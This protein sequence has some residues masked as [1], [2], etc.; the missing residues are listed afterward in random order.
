MRTPRDVFT[1]TENLRSVRE[2]QQ[3]RARGGKDLELPDLTKEVHREIEQFKASK[4]HHSQLSKD[5]IFLLSIETANDQRVNPFFYSNLP[6]LLEQETWAP[7]E[8]MLIL[9]GIDPEAAVVD[10]SYENF[11]GA[12]VQAPQIRRADWFAGSDLYGWPIPEDF[13]YTVTQLKSLIAKA[14]ESGIGE[15]EKD[16]LNHKL[17]ELEQ[18]EGNETSNFKQFILRL[19]ASMLGVLKKRWDSSDHDASKRRSPAFFVRWAETRGFEIE[20]AQWARDHAYLEHEPPATA[21]PYFDADA[22]DYPRL[23]HIGVR[24]WEYARQTTGGTAK[25]RINA[26]LVE[27]YPDL[28][29]SEREAISMISNWQ[30]AGG[31]P[32]KGG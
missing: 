12:V 5:A 14:E 11:T 23:L 8:A 7:T 2:L 22:E 21:A 15:E 4:L 19:R 30:K 3:D 13:G 26:Y 1:Y 25:Q 24:A 27:R 28:S 18:W 17:E 9:V 20:W 10:W 16:A 6:S 29:V 32:R 31:R